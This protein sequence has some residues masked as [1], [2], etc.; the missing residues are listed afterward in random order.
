M[1]EVIW[2]DDATGLRIATLTYGESVFGLKSAEKLDQA[3]KMY[4][5][6]LSLHPLLGHREPLLRHRTDYIFRS[7]LVHRNYKLIYV[8]E[9]EDIETAERVLIIDLW[10]TRMDPDFLAAR[11][12]S[13]EQS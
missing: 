4:G 13:S 9:P 5:R 11:I 7:I 3:F 1:A 2:S 12:P 10:D 8:L 6:L